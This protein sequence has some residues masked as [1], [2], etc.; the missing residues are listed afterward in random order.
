MTEQSDPYENAIAERVNGILKQE[1]S[2]GEG[3]TDYKMAKREIK[4]AIFL[5]NTRRPHFSCEMMT[6]QQAHVSG[7][8]KLKSWKKKFSTTG[9]PVVENK[10]LILE[11]IDTKSVNQF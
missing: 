10:S 4:N 6:P 8:Y 5:Y 9:M 2:I 11:K 3:F 7:R 1:F